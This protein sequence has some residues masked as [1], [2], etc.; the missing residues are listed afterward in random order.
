MRVVL[1]RAKKSTCGNVDLTRCCF[2]PS[3]DK[4]RETGAGRCR[5]MHWRRCAKKIKRYGRAEDLGT[6]SCLPNPCMY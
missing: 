2:Y 3:L 6:G 5:I 1:R 4:K